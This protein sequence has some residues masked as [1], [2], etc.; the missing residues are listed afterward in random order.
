MSSRLNELV[1]LYCGSHY[2]FPF[3]KLHCWLGFKVMAAQHRRQ[4]AA[5]SSV[6]GG[7][8][9]SPHANNGDKQPYVR[10]VTGS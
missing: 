1:N 10:I 3:E 4:E 8:P 9:S 7:H 6:K 2:Q 5:L